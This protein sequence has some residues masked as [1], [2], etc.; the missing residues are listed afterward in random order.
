MKKFVIAAAIVALGACATTKTLVP[1]GGSRSDGTVKLAYEFGMFEKPKVD[2]AAALQSATARCQAWGYQS[3][4]PFGGYQT[5]CN[6]YN[7]YGC[8]RTL[9]TVEYQCNGAGTPN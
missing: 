5:Q 1:V 7:G 9:V 6:A 8:A 2:A 4:E 3:A